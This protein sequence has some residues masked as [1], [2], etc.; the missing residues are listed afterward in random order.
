MTFDVSLTNKT[1]TA[2]GYLLFFC[3][4]FTISFL[5]EKRNRYECMQTFDFQM[6]T[7]VELFS[8]AIK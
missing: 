2:V 8:I 4:A 7:N 1:K 6:V 3:F 5:F